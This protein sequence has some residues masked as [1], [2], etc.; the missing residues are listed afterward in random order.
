[1]PSSNKS[2]PQKDTEAYARLTS[3]QH[4]TQNHFTE[5]QKIEGYFEN[6]DVPDF[7]GSDRLLKLNTIYGTI[8]LG[9]SPQKGQSFLFANIKTSIFDTAASRYQ[10]ELKDYQMMRQQKTGTQNLAYTSKRRASSAV[11]LYKADTMPWSKRSIA[12]Y[13]HRVNVEALRKTM[14]FLD[15]EQERGEA[16][17]S[18]QKQ[19]QLQ[20]KLTGQLQQGKYADMSKTRAEQTALSHRQ[21]ELAALLYRKDTQQRLFFRKLNIAFDLQKADMFAYYRQLRR[22]ARAAKQDSGPAEQPKNNNEDQDE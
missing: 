5:H 8:Q 2:F 20:E 11:I 10:R 1:M 15:I 17:S 12:P 19:K 13:L 7:M 3:P 16:E 22:D 4:V 14:P 21:D 6:R 18:R 9:Y